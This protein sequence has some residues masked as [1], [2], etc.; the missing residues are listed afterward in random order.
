MHFTPDHPIFCGRRGRRLRWLRPRRGQFGR[1]RGSDRR[2]SLRPVV[3]RRRLNLKPDGEALFKRLQR[4]EESS[5][6][7]DTRSWGF[8]SDVHTLLVAFPSLRTPRNSQRVSASVGQYKRELLHLVPG[9][10]GSKTVPKLLHCSFDRLV[11]DQSQFALIQL[12]KPFDC[13]V[14]GGFIV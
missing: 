7:L 1:G 10:F 3:G 5:R 9:K 6:G 8:W 14:Y 2:G 12:P 13:R 4:R 11:L